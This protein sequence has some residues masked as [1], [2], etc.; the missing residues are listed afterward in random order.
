M[1]GEAL[2]I[3]GVWL[4]VTVVWWMGGYP[5]RWLWCGFSG[6]LF[7]GAAAFCASCAV[8]HQPGF[9]IVG[10]VA[11]V[12]F[13]ATFVAQFFFGDSGKRRWP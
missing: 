13:A 7:I 9:F 5:A 2:V 10:L 4:I 3:A 12:I 11:A 1:I 8:R 6:S